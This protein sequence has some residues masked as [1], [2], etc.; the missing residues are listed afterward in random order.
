MQPRL[1]PRL[2]DFRQRLDVIP[3]RVRDENVPELNLLG[4]DAIETGF[5]SSPVSNSAPS[6][7]TS[8]QTRK[9]FTVNP[10]P[11]RGEHADFAPCGQILCAGSQPLAMAS[12]F[13]RLSP[14]TFCQRWKIDFFCGPAGFFK[15]WTIPFSEMPAALATAAAGTL[16]IALALRMMSPDVSNSTG[17]TISA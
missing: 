11:A 1:R 3:M 4:G 12:S 2:A 14:M 15:P 5:A 10:S 13:C 9:Q 7:V 8:S 6:Q 16:F 17:G